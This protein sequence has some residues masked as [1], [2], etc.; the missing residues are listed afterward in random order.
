MTLMEIIQKDYPDLLKVYTP[1]QLEATVE[2][3]TE[4]N[5][6]E[7]LALMYL[8]K[9]SKEEWLYMIGEYLEPN[10]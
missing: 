6:K 9:L 7:D 5:C 2:H 1:S 10:T 3:L 8:Q 4:G